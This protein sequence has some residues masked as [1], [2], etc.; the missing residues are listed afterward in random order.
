MYVRS[1][2]RLLSR[3]SLP[4][5]SLALHRRLSAQNASLV[6]TSLTLAP[7]PGPLSVNHWAGQSSFRSLRRFERVGL[8][9]PSS[10]ALRRL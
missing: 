8:T 5:R 1:Y 3:R 4:A 9:P 7:Y 10:D 2:P 6:N